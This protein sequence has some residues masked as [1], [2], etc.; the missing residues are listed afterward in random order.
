MTTVIAQKRTN[1]I[2]K[3]LL[4]VCQDSDAFLFLSKRGTILSALYQCEGLSRRVR[5]RADSSVPR[6]GINIPLE[7]T[8]IIYSKLF[9]NTWPCKHVKTCET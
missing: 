6:T 8:C 4:S 2:R 5:P 3:D 1:S 9:V 7:S